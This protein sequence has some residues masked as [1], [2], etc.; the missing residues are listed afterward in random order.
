MIPTHVPKIS[1]THEVILKMEG[2]ETKSYRINVDKEE[3]NKSYSFPD[4]VKIETDDDSS[5]SSS[6]S[7]GDSS[8]S[9]DS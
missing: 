5:S 8:S 7:S 1:G 4:L 2:Y 3:D 6:A 9:S